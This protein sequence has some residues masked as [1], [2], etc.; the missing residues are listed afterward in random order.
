MRPENILIVDNETSVSEAMTKVVVSMGYPCHVAHDGS[1]ALELI[2]NNQFDIIISNIKLPEI[3]G[4][5]LMAR[6]QA[7]TPDT[8]FIIITG[9]TGEY[10]YDKV[11]GAGAGDFIKKPFTP[12]ELKNKLKRVL[13][14]RRL[15]LENQRLLERQAEMN[16][17]LS[18]IL[19]MAT[20]LTSEL[21][22]DRLFQLIIGKVTDA[23]SAERTSLYVIDWDQGE[24]WTKVAEQVGQIRLPMGEGISGRV[25]QTGETLN[26][27]DA[28]D[29]PYFNREFD[30]KH[31]FRTRSVLCMP[32]KNQLGQAIGVIQVINK[33]NGEL[34]SPEDENLLKSLS[35]Q[36]GI[37]LENSLLH[38]EIRLS[39][40]SSI[41]TLSATVDARHPLTAGHSNRVTTY[42][43]LIGQE[44]NLS[45]E[46]LDVLKY[47]ALLH[48]IGKIGIR[49]E[50]LLKDGPF[51]PEEREEM[52]THPI[53]TKI[54][55]NEFHFPRYLSQV[56]EWAAHHHE[57]VNGRGYPDGL[58]GKEMHLGSKILAV[59]DVF[60]ALTSARDYPKYPPTKGR[61]RDPMPLERVV[62]I[63]KNDIGSH[64]D[65]AV[66]EAF[67][68]CLPQALLSYRGEHF[69]PEYVDEMIRS[70]DPT[71]LPEP[72]RE[73]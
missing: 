26:V 30:K 17:R 68:R 65:G 23:M 3:D 64:F 52:N 66:V 31:N 63:L 57:K 14:E 28:W 42:S 8:A 62:S 54:I 10:S 6:V 12:Q 59:A 67:L 2:K 5:E 35:A 22:V 47:A 33:K 70:L 18:T 37:A 19:A 7:M 1:Q 60:D 27:A 49:D 36:V 69:T 4:L 34:F 72:D 39:F 44:L 48:D 61:P 51:T 43:M 45:E 46:D 15:Q 71:L 32:V 9:Y 13:F 38:E 53:K 21:D 50:V 25:A 40:E 41:R 20:D 11:M 58:T 55:L 56:P 73:T 29:L 16:E 24:I